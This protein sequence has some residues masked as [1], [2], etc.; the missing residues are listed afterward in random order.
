ML[1]TWFIA[2]RPWSFTAA[3]IPVALGAAIAWNEGAFDPFLFVLTALGGIIMQAGTNLINT[4]GDYISGVD[5]VESAVTCPQLVTGV[6]RPRDMK[7][8]GIGAFALAGLIGF[9]LAWLRGW[10]I[11]AIGAVGTLGG[12][13][14]T[15]GWRPYKY[16]GLGSTFVFFLMGPLMVWPSYYIQTGHHSWL[17]VLVSLPVGF[18][19]S[20]ILHANDL[21]DMTEDRRTGI[22]TLALGIGFKRSILLYF[23][24]YIGAYGCLG[25]LVILG[26]IPWTAALPVILLPLAVRMFSLTRQA[27]AG[28][29]DKMIMLERL[30]AG[31]HFQFGLLFVLGLAVY[32]FLRGWLA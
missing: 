16:L 14:Y 11:L 10:P 30:T 19:V 2:L 1:K 21:R 5:T 12:Y 8:A 31:F 9:Y 6:L 15:A 28:C 3:F 7:L 4:Y 27:A 24:L 26:L 13:C 20:A 25:L 18:L 17:P 29:R 32:P 22:S 23:A